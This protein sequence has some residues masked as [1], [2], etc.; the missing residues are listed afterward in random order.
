MG[1]VASTAAKPA[2]AIRKRRM[3]QGPLA[4]RL[5]VGTPVMQAHTTAADRGSRIQGTTKRPAEL[6]LAS[7]HVK[8]VVVAVRRRSCTGL[9]GPRSAARTASLRTDAPARSQRPCR[10]GLHGTRD[11]HSMT[12]DRQAQL[13]APIRRLVRRWRSQ[14]YKRH[15]LLRQSVRRMKADSAGKSTRPAPVGGRNAPMRCPSRRTT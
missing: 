13:A 6:Q 9:Q 7:D 11:C 12:G 10:Q 1:A 5:E 14:C 15:R 2:R 4:G 8:T 3:D